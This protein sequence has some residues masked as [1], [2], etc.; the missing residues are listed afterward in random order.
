[1]YLCKCKLNP[2]DFFPHSLCHYRWPC[3]RA[4]LLTI[5]I[6]FLLYDHKQTPHQICFK[7]VT[8]LY[9]RSTCQAHGGSCMQFT[10]HGNSRQ[11]LVRSK[12]RR[13]RR[14]AV[15][16]HEFLKQ[17]THKLRKTQIT[18]TKHTYSQTRSPAF[19]HSPPS[20]CT[21]AWLLQSQHL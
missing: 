9:E 12:D 15:H 6:L 2:E 4:L 19:L 10:S 21:T 11:N 7:Y 8:G 16:T 18:N 1:M 14:Q 20:W 13:D 17:Y 5:Q 3:P